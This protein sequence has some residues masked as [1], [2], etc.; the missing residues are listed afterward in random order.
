MV[1]FLITNYPTLAG[2]GIWVRLGHITPY[3]VI[4]FL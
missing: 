2:A 3:Q 4:I 1:V